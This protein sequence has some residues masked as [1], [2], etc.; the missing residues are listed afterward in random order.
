MDEHRMVSCEFDLGSSNLSYL[1]RL[2]TQRSGVVT[3]YHH[4]YLH[5]EDY[6][7]WCLALNTEGYDKRRFRVRWGWAIRSTADSWLIPADY[8]RI[9]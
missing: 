8:K 4:V 1:K 3:G 2:A 9:T 6:R 5:P 7:R